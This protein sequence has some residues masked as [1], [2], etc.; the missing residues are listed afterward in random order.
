[1]SAEPTKLRGD[2]KAPWAELS[3]NQRRAVE[4]QV[5]GRSA[6]EIAGKFHVNRTTAWRWLT[7]PASLEYRR[8]LVS[9]EVGEIRMAMRHITRSAIKQYEAAIEAGDLEMAKHWM[10]IITKNNELLEYLLS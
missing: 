9:Q 8:Y 2:G 5:V 10:S 7:K 3:D 1:M 6:A 4:L